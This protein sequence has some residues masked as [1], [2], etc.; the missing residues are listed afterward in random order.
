LLLI[1]GEKRGGGGGKI[2]VG[3]GDG[4]KAAGKG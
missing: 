3:N 4:E 1:G 2:R